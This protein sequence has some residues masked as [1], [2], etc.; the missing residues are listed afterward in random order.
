[1]PHNAARITVFDHGFLLTTKYEIVPVSI[2]L[3]QNLNELVHVSQKIVTDS[4][5]RRCEIHRG[6]SSHPID[7]EN[8]SA[9]MSRHSRPLK[10]RHF[11][12]IRTFPVP[13]PIPPILRNIGLSYLTFTLLLILIIY[14][15]IRPAECSVTVL[16]ELEL[17][18]TI[19][20][21]S[22]QRAG[23]LPRAIYSALNQTLTNIEVLVVDDQS[24][25][26]SRD[27]VQQFIARD[28]RVRLVAHTENSGTHMARIT[29]VLQ[30]RGTYILSLDADDEIPPAI[31]EDSV[32]CALLHSVDVVE[33]HVLKSESG[34]VRQFDF[35]NP[36]FIQASRS[37]VI[38]IFAKHELNW[39][40][41]K[42]LVKR[43][44]Y[45]KALNILTGAIREKRVIYAEDK[46]HFGLI[47]LVSNGMYFLKEPGY[48]YYT[49]IPG[50]SASE[51]Q[52]TKDEC[53]RQLRFVD[54]A[55][56]YFFLAVANVSYEKW[57]FSPSEFGKD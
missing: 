33:F 56:K 2:M 47:C 46:L 20:I 35:L 29:G 36:P 51:T 4:D 23:W 26:S 27:V 38:A 5:R 42:R 28:P 8:P 32:H 25:D 3:I 9:L 30:A 34:M 31:G 21:P 22:Y 37:E 57:P 18:L 41:W 24:T 54:K 39:N 19:L 16:P 10:P 55:L 52:Q 15:L 43:D 13:P 17:P 49:D 14:F 11:D 53:I 50:N 40:I 7:R 45:M 1:L 48:L 6:G 12:P 44:V